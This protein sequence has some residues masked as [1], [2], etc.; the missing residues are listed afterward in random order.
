VNISNNTLYSGDNLDILRSYIPNES[1]DLVYL[2]PPFNSHAEYNILFK[3][4]SGQGSDAQIQAFSDF[5]HWD[6]QAKHAYDYLTLEA[7]NQNVANLMEALFKFLGKNDMLAY[8]VMMGVRLL[9]LH[10]VLKQ[11]GSIF[12]HCDPTSSHYLKILLDSIFDVKNFRNEIVWKRTSAHTGEGKI[13]THGR[14]HDILLFYSKGEKYTFNPQYTPH[15]PKYLETEG[16]DAAEADANL[17]LANF[18]K[19]VN[20][21]KA[22]GRCLLLSSQAYERSRAIDNSNSLYTKYILEGFQGVKSTKDDKGREIPAS[23]DQNGNVTPESLHDYVY[24]KVA[25]EANQVP[26]IKS[27]KSSKII[28]ANYENLVDRGRGR[29]KKR[30]ENYELLKLLE[31]GKIGEF[32]KIRAHQDMPLYLREEDLSEKNLQGA[33]LHEA[34]LSGIKL[35]NAKL[36]TANLKGAILKDADLS[37]AE[38]KSADLYGANLSGANLSG[39]NLRGADLKGM[40][41]FSGANLSHANLRGA[42]LSG[43]VNLAGAVLHD[44]DF[45]GCIADKGLINFDAADIRNVIGLPVLH[46][47]NKYVDELKTFAEAINQ[48]FKTHNLPAE[49]LKPIE[50]SMKELANELEDV[51]EPENIS[52][53]RK[54]FHI[55]M[56][57]SKLLD[58]V[59]KALPVSVQPQ[60]LFKT[61]FKPLC[62]INAIGQ[63]WQGNPEFYLEMNITARILQKQLDAAESWYN[64]GNALNGLSKYNEAINC[65]DKVIEI[66]PHHA[67]AWYNKGNALNSLGMNKEAKASFARAKEA[68][69]VYRQ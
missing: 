24:Y 37:G 69:E 64:K 15:D 34:D 17:A 59:I 19:I 9:E 14:I 10:K 52:D 1:I 11:T 62:F 8:L 13:L 30:S 7:P 67:D 4:S 31:D 29:A 2:D 33:D 23:V 53:V 20:I 39:A 21:P 27:D 44:V 63:E 55:N 40:I 48:H 47:P 49:E 16:E 35:S 25:N 58:N 28:L 26:K 32:N 65:Y 56:K 61:L 45:T 42:D 46:K 60:D 3:E 38:L 51:Q 22:E 41:D 36:N 12:L 57:F 6:I 54:I 5:W 50:E 43:M 66:I 68:K 18:D